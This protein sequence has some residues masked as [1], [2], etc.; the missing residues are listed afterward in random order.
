MNWI[1]ITVPLVLLVLSIIHLLVITLNQ[2][3]FF[4][5]ILYT[6]LFDHMIWKKYRKLKQYMKD[7]TIP[8]IDIAD[9]TG[10]NVGFAFIK[11]DNT[12]FVLQ[13]DEIYIS[14]YYKHLISNLLKHNNHATRRALQ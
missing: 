4:F 11:Y 13:E 6:F 8:I 10:N 12:I 1:I 2:C 5:Q 7:N 9:Y 14:S 3:N